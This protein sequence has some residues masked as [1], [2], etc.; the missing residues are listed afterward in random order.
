MFRFLRAKSSEVAVFIQCTSARDFCVSDP[1]GSGRTG[2]HVRPGHRS[3]QAWQLKI[4][5]KLKKDEDYLLMGHF[6]LPCFI[7]R[8][9]SYMKTW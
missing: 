7:T 5:Y 8:G 3:H 1:S 4:T 2:R 6:S 9:F